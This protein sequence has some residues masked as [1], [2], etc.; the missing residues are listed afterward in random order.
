VLLFGA[1]FLAQHH[2]RRKFGAKYD[3]TIA[4]DDILQEN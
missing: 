4:G 2:W 1:N 3:R